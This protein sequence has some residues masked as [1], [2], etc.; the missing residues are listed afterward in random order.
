MLSRI[1]VTSGRRSCLV[2]SRT[3]RRFL[4]SDAAAT[5]P[6]NPMQSNFSRPLRQ[7]VTK[8]EREANRAARKVQATKA[9]QQGKEGAESAG[10]GTAKAISKHSRWVWYMGVAVPSALIVWG[11]NDEN[12]P[13]KKVADAIGF[14]NLVRNF[15]EDFAKPSHE[16]LLPDWSQVR[17]VRCFLFYIVFYIVCTVLGWGCVVF[18]LWFNVKFSVF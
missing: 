4:S 18:C 9:L 7:A 16:K 11:M 5:A 6:S 12:S 17:I 15:S 14:T 8:E 1:V 3:S 10:G 2:S 13:P